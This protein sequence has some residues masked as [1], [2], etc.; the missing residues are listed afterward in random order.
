MRKSNREFFSLSASDSETSGSKIARK[1]NQLK[2][3]CKTGVS[4]FFTLK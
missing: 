1:K 3:L 4:E 2:G